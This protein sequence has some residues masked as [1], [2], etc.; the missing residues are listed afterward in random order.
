MV[1]S[2][3]VFTYS[4]SGSANPYRLAF[5]LARGFDGDGDEF[6][7]LEHLVNIA[8]LVGE[9]VKACNPPHFDDIELERIEQVGP[10]KVLWPEDE[11]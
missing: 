8:R 3:Y 5:G 4:T 10:R 1:E 7:G 6:N 2:H 11:G 9:G